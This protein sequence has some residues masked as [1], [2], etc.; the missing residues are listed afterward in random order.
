VGYRDEYGISIK[1]E[2]RKRQTAMDS[3]KEV[4]KK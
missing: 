1:K 4:E 2:K 3:R